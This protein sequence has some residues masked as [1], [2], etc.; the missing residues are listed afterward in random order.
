MISQ[1]LAQSDGSIAGGLVAGGFF[2]FM[3][4]VGLVFL[5]LWVWSL[6]S[7]IKNKSLDDTTRLVWVL[8]IV[9]TGIIGS[10]L[11]VLFGRNSGK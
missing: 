10:A 1:I 3:L 2:L 9:F 7:A 5:V 11:Y 8:V 4:L 6:V